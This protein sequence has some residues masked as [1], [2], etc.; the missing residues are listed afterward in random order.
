MGYE[1]Y[2]TRA[3]FYFENE[4]QWITSEEWLHLVEEDPELQ[5]AGYN[6]DYFALWSGPSS[7]PEPWL[8]WFEGNVHSKHPDD[9]LIDKMVEIAKKLNAKVQGDDGEIYIGGGSENFLPAPEPDAPESPPMPAKS[10]L[11]W[12]FGGR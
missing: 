11:R 3:K 1:L 2:I 5:L 9:P 7:Y 10:W 6:S 8:D 4:G 12:L